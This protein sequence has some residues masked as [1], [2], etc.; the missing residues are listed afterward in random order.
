VKYKIITTI[1]IIAIILFPA[2]SGATSINP[3]RGECYY[4]E[5]QTPIQVRAIDV[6]FS[7]HISIFEGRTINGPEAVGGKTIKPRTL[8]FCVS[9][10]EPEPR[11]VPEPGTVLMLGAGLLVLFVVGS[12]GRKGR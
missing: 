1:S 4:L 5:H 12:K 2:L 3:D 8:K 7:R 11:P 6:D 9:G 10:R